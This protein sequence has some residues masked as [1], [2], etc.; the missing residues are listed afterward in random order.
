MPPW[1][2]SQLPRR[3]LQARQGSM[4]SG[5]LCGHPH[6]RGPPASSNSGRTRHGRNKGFLISGSIAW[7]SMV[8][9][10]IY[11][12]NLIR[13]PAIPGMEDLHYVDAIHCST[14]ADLSVENHTPWHQPADPETFACAR[15][16]RY[17]RS[18]SLRRPG[19]FCGR[20]YR[21]KVCTP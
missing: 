18:T 1:P 19:H 11:R 16:Y 8:W 6:M 2:R 14:G 17:H 20:D 4:A 9:S 5:S 12:F 3:L 10:P 13:L 7:Q 21:K 15:Q